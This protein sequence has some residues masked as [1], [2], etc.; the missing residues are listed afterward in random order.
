M[1]VMLDWRGPDERGVLRASD[2]NALYVIFRDESG[3]YRVGFFP[4]PGLE[5]PWGEPVGTEVEAKAAAEAC[6]LHVLEMRKRLAGQA[7]S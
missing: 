3:H 5:C 2:E 1:H 7:G 6:V 4:S